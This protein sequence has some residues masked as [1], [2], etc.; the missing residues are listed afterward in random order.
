MQKEITIGEIFGEYGEAYITRNRVKGQ[1]KGLIRLLSA[2]RTNALGNHFEQCNNCAYT[3]KAYDSCRNRHCPV[4]QQKDKLQ[5]LDKRMTE[6]LPVGYYHLVFTVPH[7]LNPLCLQNKKA[8]YG[9][10]F[11][12]ASQT[13]LGLA[14]DTKHLGADI[15]LMTVLH[16]WGQNMMEHP[17]LHCIMP[18]GGLGFDKK[19]WVHAGNKNGFFVHY[20]AL[21]RKFRGKFLDLLKQAIDGNQLVFKGKLAQIAGKKALGIFVGKL[22]KKEWVMNIQ[23]PLGHPEKILE[24]LSRYVFRIAITNR[25]IIE[26]KD[27]KVLFSWKD[28]RTGRSRKMRLDIDEFIRRFLLHVL[29]KGFFKV[30]SY[31]IF[32]NRYRRQNIETAKKNPATRTRGCQRGGYGRW[33][34]GVGKTRYGVGRN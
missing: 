27:G 23:A 9:I 2:C 19:H 29:P 32:A 18:A 22:Y 33:H 15:G 24:Y 8:M 12:A 16:T 6:L 11:K 28:Y 25:R 7:E 34:N 4:C 10:L 17:H 26:V 21:S 5:W 30:R 31:G 3:T 14:R 20:K 13:L 1:E